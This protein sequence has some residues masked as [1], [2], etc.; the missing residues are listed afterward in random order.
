MH[1]HTIHEPSF[2]A[3]LAS[4]HDQIGLVLIVLAFLYHFSIY[5]R[6]LLAPLH[7]ARRGLAARLFH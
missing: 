1:Q 5:H 4:H 7:R 6:E 2:G 3:Y